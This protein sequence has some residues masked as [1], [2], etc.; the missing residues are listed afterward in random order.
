MKTRW[1]LFFALFLIEGC[2]D[3]G[4]STNNKDLEQNM[5]DLKIYQEN[6]GDHIKSKNLEDASWL[7]EGMDSI[8]HILNKRFNEHHKL[9]EPF[10][11]YYKRRMRSPVQGLRKAIH[12]NDTAKA[13]DNYELLVKRC[14]NCHADNDIDKEV[15]F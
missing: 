12:K 7:L 5:M 8:L 13:L 4:G 1:I 14:N 11:Y 2:N 6:L 10:S 3:N 15:R 9:S